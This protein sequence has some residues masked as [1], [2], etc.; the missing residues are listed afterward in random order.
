M[1]SNSNHSHS[2]LSNSNYS[3]SNHSHPNL[4]N[5]NHSHPSLS[6][7]N[8]SHPS[9]YGRY[10]RNL[11]ALILIVVIIILT[12]K[13]GSYFITDDRCTKVESV[14]ASVQIKN[15]DSRTYLGLN[16]DTDSL[17]F[18]SVSSGTTVKRSINVQSSDEA[19]V[20]VTMAGSLTAWTK[21]SPAE[22]TLSAK[23]N[24]MVFFDLNVP[25]LIPEGNYTGQVNFCFMAR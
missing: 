22:F 7:S 8:H 14:E 21:I 12:I 5:S 25:E 16:T 1:T 10:G 18:G 24:R 9:Q 4:P 11:I 20:K 2:S 3:N 15:I 17:K 23:E 19:L 13:L 6:N